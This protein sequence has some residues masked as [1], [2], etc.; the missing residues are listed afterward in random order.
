MNDLPTRD[1]E[2][3]TGKKFVDQKTKPRAPFPSHA[4]QE[5]AHTQVR[6]MAHTQHRKHAGN[7]AHTATADSV[8]NQHIPSFTTPPAEIAEPRRRGS[9]ARP[10][11]VE[12]P[13][14]GAPS[15]AAS[16]RSARRRPSKKESERSEVSGAARSEQAV[17]PSRSARSPE[18]S[19]AEAK[20]ESKLLRPSAIAGN[21]RTKKPPDRASGGKAP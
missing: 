21:K 7:G 18:G 12:E 14:G 5:K 1:F 4:V 9:H 20:I 8:G 19:L 3:W 6:E 17:S 13:C 2:R 10:A 16:A 11:S 15:G